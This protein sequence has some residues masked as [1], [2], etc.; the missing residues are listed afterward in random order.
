MNSCA[1]SINSFKGHNAVSATAKS[2]DPHHL[3]LAGYTTDLFKNKCGLLFDPISLLT[4]KRV[5]A[6]RAI[7][8]SILGTST[9][10]ATAAKVT[11]A[12]LRRTIESERVWEQLRDEERE[13][14]FE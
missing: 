4:D 6:S 13:Q 12:R 8:M 9:G 1:W 5:E 3:L 2:F 7:G 10:I 11:S 14:R